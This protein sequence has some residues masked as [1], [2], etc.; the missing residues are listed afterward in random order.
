MMNLS[1]FMMIDGVAGSGK[2][3]GV[4]RLLAAVLKLEDPS[5]EIVA[6]STIDDRID[7]LAEAI[8]TEN[9]GNLITGILDNIFMK[10]DG[11]T[12]LYSEVRSTYKNQYR[13]TSDN[14]IIIHYDHN[15]IPVNEMTTKPI[16]VS[17]P[18]AKRVVYFIDEVT[19]VTEDQMQALVKYVEK[20]NANGI[21]ASIIGLG[22]ST[23]SHAYNPDANNYNSIADC[24]YLRTPQLSVSLRKGNRGKRDNLEMMEK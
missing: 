5:C 8:E 14:K 4:A 23:Q 24:N 11:T 19:Q 22:D 13:A 2:S 15:E 16:L 18:D 6:L 3:Q 7:T 1:N 21:D 12:K 10:P 20:L 9:K 17:N